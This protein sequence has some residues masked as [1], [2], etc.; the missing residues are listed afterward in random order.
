[1]GT[2]GSYEA[3]THF[4]QLLA[5][6]GM[7][8]KITITKHG[9]PVAN[10]TPVAKETQ[11]DIAHAV[12]ELQKFRKGKKLRGLKVRDLISEGRK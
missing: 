11:D 5:R 3:K 6:V 9:V 7:G 10:L 2:V 8:E 12:A 4:S 1:M